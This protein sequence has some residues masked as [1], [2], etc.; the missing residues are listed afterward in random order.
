MCY[1]SFMEE[2]MTEQQEIDKMY[3]DFLN[4][5]EE[6]DKIVTK[7]KKS[8]TQQTKEFA[9]FIEKNNCK[10]KGGNNGTNNGRK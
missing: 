9:Q 1:N 7:E 3:K 8:Y 6:N 4:E 5:L 10:I 2:N